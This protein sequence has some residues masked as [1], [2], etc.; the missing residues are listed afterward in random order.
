[1]TCSSS[2]RPGFYF[3]SRP[4]AGKIKTN[5]DL[6]ALVSPRF[7]HYSCFTLIYS[8]LFQVFFFFS[9]YLVG[10]GLN[11]LGQKALYSSIQ[12]TTYS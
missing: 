11:I 4:P 3:G 2:L 8:C 12:L 1:M 7:R 5:H 6:V 9:D 10:F